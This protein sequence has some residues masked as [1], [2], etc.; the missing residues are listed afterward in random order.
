MFG[1]AAG[2]FELVVG[3]GHIDFYALPKLEQGGSALKVEA[4]GCCAL[5]VFAVGTGVAMEGGDRYLD[6]GSGQGR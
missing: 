1:A 2:T 4:F 3:G 6:G 5:Q